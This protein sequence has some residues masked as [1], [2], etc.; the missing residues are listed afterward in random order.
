MA[1]QNFEVDG[2]KAHFVT[3]ANTLSHTNNYSVDLFFR[4]EEP[5][6][7]LSFAHVPYPRKGEVRELKGNGFRE[8]SWETTSLNRRSTHLTTSLIEPIFLRAVHFVKSLFFHSK[9]MRHFVVESYNRQGRQLW[10]PK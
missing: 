10:K 6:H 3:N 8:I 9:Q 2:E 5:M 1:S 7:P 4:F